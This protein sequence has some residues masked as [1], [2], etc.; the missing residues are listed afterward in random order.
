MYISYVVLIICHAMTFPKFISLQCLM[1]LQVLQSVINGA[2]E[3][4]LNEVLPI[5]S[6]IWG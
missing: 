5:M 3:L 2:G 4:S 6:E 1:F